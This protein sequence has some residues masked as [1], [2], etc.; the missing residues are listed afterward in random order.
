MNAA[1][2]LNPNR[3]A[4]VDPESLLHFLSL[5]SN[6]AADK[7]KQQQA[8]QMVAHQNQ[9]KYGDDDE[10]E[11][12]EEEEEEEENENRRSQKKT[13][14][15]GHDNTGDKGV[16][17]LGNNNNASRPDINSLPFSTWSETSRRLLATQ[18]VSDTQ[19]DSSINS[20]AKSQIV[21]HDLI[22]TLES[23]LM[24][25]K[26][27]SSNSSETAEKKGTRMSTTDPQQTAA[28]LKKL[29]SL[30]LRSGE[31]GG[32]MSQTK[33]GAQVVNIVITPTQPGQTS[34]E[35]ERQ[36]I[37]FL[38]SP[39]VK[40]L[41]QAAMNDPSLRTAAEKISAALHTPKSDSD[42][43]SP[44]TYTNDFNTNANEALS[45][46]SCIPQ[47]DL[48]QVS[49]SQGSG[50]PVNPYLTTS[51][52]PDGFPLTGN[53]FLNL[54][55]PNLQFHQ[56]LHH[57][58]ANGSA[59]TSI[60]ATTKTNVINIFVL[61]FNPALSPTVANIT[62]TM[63]KVPHAVTAAAPEEAEEYEVP[64]RPP[65]V[66]SLHNYRH[67]P[68]SI[69]T[70]HDVT[71]ST[72]RPSL[73]SQ[74]LFFNKMGL[75]SEGDE[76]D[77]AKATDMDKIITSQ[78]RPQRYKPFIDVTSSHGTPYVAVSPS[79]TTYRSAPAPDPTTERVNILDLL[80][81]K[82]DA[83]T[84]V[85]KFG[86]ANQKPPPHLTGQ[87]GSQEVVE[88]EMLDK[89]AAE[90]FTYLI[91]AEKE[92][93]HESSSSS[94]STTM[95]PW[96]KARTSTT[97]TTEKPSSADSLLLPPEFSHLSW[98]LNQQPPP[99]PHV[100]LTASNLGTKGKPTPDSNSEE[101]YEY[102]EST[103][104]LEDKEPSFLQPPSF[105][106]NFNKRVGEPRRNESETSRPLPIDKRPLYEQIL[107]SSVMNFTIPKQNATTQLRLSA[108]ARPK[109]KRKASI[110]K[111]R[112]SQLLNKE[113]LLNPE[114]KQRVRK[115][116]A[117][118][119]YSALPTL[120]AGA[121][122]TWPYWVPIV[123]TG[124][125]R[126]SP[127]PNSTT[128]TNSPPNDPAPAARSEL[129]LS[130]DQF[131][132]KLSPSSSIEF[133][134]EGGELKMESGTDGPRRR[135]EDED[136]ALVGGYPLDEKWIRVEVITTESSSPT[137]KA[138]SKSGGVL[139]GKDNRQFVN[140]ESQDVPLL[141]NFL[142]NV[143][144]NEWNI[145]T[146][147]PSPITRKGTTPNSHSS[148]SSSAPVLGSSMI[149]VGTRP[150]GYSQ[151][152]NKLPDPLKPYAENS[153]TNNNR[154]RIKTA[155]ATQ[156]L[157]S[158]SVSASESH[159]TSSSSSSSALS[160]SQLLISPPKYETSLP[161]FSGQSVN[162]PPRP[163]RPNNGSQMKNQR[164]I[165]RTPVIGTFN[166][167]A[168]R[169]RNRNKRKRLGAKI[170]E[171][172]TAYAS[173]ALLPLWLPILFGNG[174]QRLPSYPSPNQS[175]L[176]NHYR[177]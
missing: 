91:H 146:T 80:P 29:M 114:V 3:T 15:R 130:L 161:P 101:D 27:S 132:G 108:T 143:L 157:D 131:A 129:N 165:H 174:I 54:N 135:K 9:H 53:G 144:S 56:A 94:S 35:S 51:S 73:Q 8:Q 166:E 62:E 81:G 112:P 118:L 86:G 103:S 122:A 176:S 6:E 156:S 52:S 120:A 30:L 36:K 75:P 150:S 159:L 16:E 76:E 102:D 65:V 77:G 74:A 1:W 87:D 95:R 124:R 32:G 113:S 145:S 139:R 99:K 18:N 24:N 69:I 126:R 88:P 26:N 160:P 155:Q 41:L 154:I 70:R 162:H 136:R 158:V 71:S 138:N 12:A 49:S 22:L 127:N 119:G 90:L 2:K 60:T 137:S 40:Q 19:H 151:T 85:E 173:A 10:G 141:K 68:P 104:S 11:K 39:E 97:K 152:E 47:E 121:V 42:N 177:L 93:M 25:T 169:E 167:D 64:L 78:S 61:N 7:K 14:R 45:C 110:F 111:R 20:T 58:V 37:I 92:Q 123:A 57:L 98:I 89:E 5:F 48:E 109:P 170:E 50:G 83:F 107:T 79:S 33:D 84:H 66:Y 72:P 105:H 133:G 34:E 43:L 147:T 175:F 63:M 23:L 55:H 96:I 67:K 171:A 172:E 140:G 125:K 82:M 21:L 17:E 168:E 163:T 59:P 134:R 116:M 153:N 100:G 164:P 128:T 4:K 44:Y 46:S 28:D 149:Q 38:K 13:N 115:F 142:K 106:I 148:S 117:A 31:A